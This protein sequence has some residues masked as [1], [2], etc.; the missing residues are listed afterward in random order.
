MRVRRAST[1]ARRPSAT[2]A[3]AASLALLSALAVL[4]ATPDA[5]AAHPQR[6]DAV[7]KQSPTAGSD[8]GIHVSN[9]DVP[10]VGS[11]TAAIAGLPKSTTG[12]LLAHL[13][14]PSTQ[15][16]SMVGVTWDHGGAS[17]RM[18]VE[19]RTR[20][21]GAWTSWTSLDTDADGGP[22]STRSDSSFRD[23]TE[24]EW[25]GRS[26]GVEVAVYGRGAAPAGLEVSAVD[27]GRSPAG[28]AAAESKAG[29]VTGKPGSFPR[30]PKVI[31]RK[32]W[33]ADESLGD[34]C[35]DPKYGRTF[36]AVVVHHTAGSN[37]Y[38]RKESA[39]IVRG[40]YAYHTQSRGWCDIGYNFLVDR[41]GDVFEGRDGGIRRPVRGAHAGDYNVNT[42]GISLMGNFDLVKPTVAMK[43]SL[44]SLVA[45]RLGTA[46]HHAYGKP[47]VFDHRISRISGHRDVMPTAC[48]GQ[49]VYDWLP[50]LR[51]LVNQRLGKW[52][53]PI[54]RAWQKA[55]GK[56]SRLGPVRMG[57]LGGDGGHRTV[58]Q[59]GRMYL[60]QKGMHTLFAG[61]ILDRYIALGD[62]KS[63]FGYPTTNARTV[64]DGP[65]RAVFFDKGRIYWSKRAGA[66]ALRSGAI[67]HK[68]RLLKGAAGPLGFPR[69]AVI[70]RKASAV[71]RF[72]GGTITY[73]RASDSVSVE[74][75]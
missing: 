24:P 26:T 40:V 25:V 16:F 18:T 62:I 41:F 1:H 52:A 72:Q 23:G 46:Y 59:H 69:S 55:G 73:D 13:R 61:P 54:E 35:W 60:S 9:L 28:L 8:G 20:T 14:Q 51:V 27:P 2:S 15:P 44:I 53:S 19:V 22:V 58:F 70:D 29:Q 64:G 47:F 75:R 21:G 33:G 37:D 36:K 17:G 56:D 6:R 74:Y 48:P 71:A 5:L 57:E 49:Y 68:Y 30:I 67:L 31:T 10:S 4:V 39:A 42:T 34:E 11:G 66:Q 50:R 12:R 32:Q 63:G 45:W 7:G 38:T 65:G 3:T 43:Q